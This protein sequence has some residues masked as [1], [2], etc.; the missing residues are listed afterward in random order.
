MSDSGSPPPPPDP[1]A[2]AAAQGAQNRE[3]A[4]FNAA[5]ARANQQTPWG[6]LTWEIDPNS[7][8]QYNQDA[9]ERALKAFETS[10]SSFA[11]SQTRPP[12]SRTAEGLP[13]WL[14]PGRDPN[15][16][17][18]YSL[19]D[20]NKAED[21]SVKAPVAPRLEDFKIS[22][23]APKYTSKMTL[24]DS[25]QK[26]FDQDQATKLKLSALGGR[27]ADVAGDVLDQPVDFSGLPEIETGEGA[28]QRLEEALYRR[29]ER[30][31]APRYAQAEEAERNRLLNAGFSVNGAGFDKALGNFRRE[32]DA[33]FADLSDRSIIL[34]GSEADRAFNQS[35][36]NRRQALQELLLERQLPI[37]EINALRTGSQLQLPQFSPTQGVSGMQ[38][39]DLA[40]LIGQQYQGNLGGWQADVAN[41]NANNQAGASI[42]ATAA[43]AA[44]F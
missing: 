8:P 5:L 18:S 19:Q 41:T 3:T 44:G 12:D 29:G 26:L 30:Q 10:S 35:T 24:S 15:D 42:L 7:G 27:A 2:T 33:A 37:Q 20:P 40:G 1:F 11:G 6:S 28:R 13:A 14:I 9:Y 4:A 36:A 34:G 25:Q 39:V 38:P 16:P 17:N 21:G 31:L 23:G 32:K 43:V 22:D